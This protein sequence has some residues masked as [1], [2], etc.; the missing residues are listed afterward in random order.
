MN[1]SD[2][3]F[4]KIPFNPEEL[5]KKRDHCMD[6]GFAEF[7]HIGGYSIFAIEGSC[8]DTRGGTRSVFFVKEELT[9]EEMKARI[10]SFPIAVK[11]IEQMPFSV[12]W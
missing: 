8:K 12:K 6:K 11:M 3:W 5:P 2:C 1:K 10:L 4:T 9:Q 7:Y